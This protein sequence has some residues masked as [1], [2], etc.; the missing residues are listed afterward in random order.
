M[1]HIA[2]GDEQAFRQLLEKHQNAVIGT[3]AKMLGSPT[4]AEDLSQQ[5]FLRV[6]KSAK[7]YK[8]QAKF[9]TWLFTITRNLVFTETKRRM[10]KKAQSLDE[11]ADNIDFQPVSTRQT[12]DE[13][14]RDK[15]LQNAIDQ[16]ISLLPKTQRLA[17]ILRRYEDMP[18]EEIA[19]ILKTSVSSVKSHLFRARARLREDLKHYLEN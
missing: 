17:V 18:Y 13:D 19:Q 11:A 10:K 4:D 15:E 9:T 14:L 3:V 16:A 1:Q 12:P 7:R 2:H 5:V 8:P 6:W